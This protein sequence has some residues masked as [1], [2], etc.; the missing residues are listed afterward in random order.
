MFSKHSDLIAVILGG[1]LG[2]SILWF[3]FA[4]QETE[5]DKLGL[6]IGTSQVYQTYNDRNVHCG[7]LTNAN[8]CIAD[9]NSHK[10]KGRIALLGWSQLH[11][12]NQYQ[13]GQHTAPWL[14]VDYYSKKNIDFVTFSQGNANPQE[15]YVFFEWL[16]SQTDLKGL[17]VGAW[18]QGMREENIRSSI[19]IA[20]QEPEVR[21]SLLS[22]EVGNKALQMI[23][24]S[25]ALQTKGSASFQDVVETKIVETLKDNVSLWR[26]REEAEGQI[27]LFFR[28]IKFNI[29][30][31][32][33]ILLGLEKENWMWPIPE[34][35][36]NKNIQFLE[37]LVEEARKNNIEVLIYV[38]PRPSDAPFPFDPDLYARFKND[39]KTFSDKYGAHFANLEDCV[40]G[41]VW[42]TT[43]DG[44]GELIQDITHFKAGGHAQLA[45][46]LEKEINK[47][48]RSIR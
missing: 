42:G 26:V 25:D 36:Y 22:T 23:E 32:R 40:T 39:V 4:N 12:V 2:L 19:A 3:L 16:M 41:D 34:A 43:K 5:F 21:D 29:V 47:N 17:V 31:L 45:K 33:N 35:R 48:F 13:E 44:D 28:N 6:G 10:V 14:L 11:G 7:D 18:M 9:T 37:T 8:L 15:H 38:P 46:C 1:V 27:R 30:K 20:M 24:S